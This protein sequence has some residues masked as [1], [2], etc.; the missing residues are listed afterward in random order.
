MFVLDV[1]LRHSSRDIEKKLVLQSMPLYEWT[2]VLYGSAGTW[3]KVESAQQLHCEA[4]I[5]QGDRLWSGMHSH[6]TRAGVAGH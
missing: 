3:L 6:S 4:Y 2:R 5:L 1:S